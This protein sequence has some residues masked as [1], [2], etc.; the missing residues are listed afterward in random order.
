MRVEIADYVEGAR[1][2]RGVV[3]VI[4]VFRA[5]TVACYAMAGGAARIIPVAGVE[6]ARALQRGHPDW[7]TIGERHARR[8]EGFD[9][10]NSPTEI[11]A[12]DLAGRTLVHTTHS[13]TQGL[14][15]AT[16]ADVVFTGALVNA[17]AVCRAVLALKPARV[18]LVRMGHEAQS[19][20][21]GDDACAE[22]LAAR[23]AGRNPDVRGLSEHLRP[24]ASLARF[25]D[26]AATWAPESD[27]ERATRVDAFDFALQLVRSTSPP[28]LARLS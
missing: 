24:A 11:E 14:A 18:T 1:A 8:L 28:E 13:G 4:D 3:V 15:N 10:G 25:F 20:C 17:A 26:P 27:F 19:P 7:L 23:L 6:E 16:Q 12:A 5:F 9:F 22:L 21:A 2:A